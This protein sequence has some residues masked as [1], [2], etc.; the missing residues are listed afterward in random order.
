LYSEIE[1]VSN[2]INSLE[3]DS[4]PNEF[5]YHIV[6]I[7]L[8]QYDSYDAIVLDVNLP[9]MVLNSWVRDVGYENYEYY[10]DDISCTI[11]V[12]DDYGSGY[13]LILLNDTIQ[14]ECILG[15]FIEAAQNL[16]Y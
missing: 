10:D 8:D 4:I 11:V 15:N 12:T 9:P 7:D 1:C 16:K 13:Y 14:D 2:E 6:I 5:E 3:D